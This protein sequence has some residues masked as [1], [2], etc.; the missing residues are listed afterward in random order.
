MKNVQVL[1]E[2]RSA[3]AIDMKKLLD[4]NQGDKWN[5]SLNEKYDQGIA[6]IE[7]IDAE[8]DRH[9]KLKAAMDDEFETQFVAERADKVAFDK[10]KPSAK[11]FAAWLRDGDKGLTAEQ[12]TEIRN[13][14]SVGGTPSEGSYTV[15]S[16]VMSTLIDTLKLFGGMR[17]EATLI[18]TDAGNPLAWP[19]SDG[20]S[21]VGELI[22]E[23]TTANAADPTFGTVAV[24]P[25]KFSSKIVAVPFELLQ[26]SQLDI[27]AFVGNRLAQRIGRIENQYFTTGSGTAQPRGVVTGAT[28][29]KVGTTGQTT[30]VIADDLIDLIHS[31]DPA[32]RVPSSCFMMHDLSLAK[33]RK[34]K[35]SSN[36]PIYIPGYDG[37]AGAMKDTLLGYDICIN[38]DIAQMAANAKSILF[39]DFSKYVIR[40]VMN[41]QLFRFADSA[42]VKLGQIG[43]LMW[44]RAGGNLV[45][46]NA[47][48][49]YANSAT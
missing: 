12:F 4:D 20:T 31:V 34:L 28:S 49:Y 33:I 39:G 48:K 32:Y 40:D 23:N 5:A 45:D 38:Q 10:R 36:R 7:A 14:L 46:S 22:A 37:L 19:T 47:V 30:T 15:E 29:G 1:R 17:Q 21:E 2:Q 26:D 13:T 6:Q 43:F 8:I 16:D 24:N 18:K 42:Y 44:A 27:E 11:Y 25:Y 35:D 41:A 9:I 3:L